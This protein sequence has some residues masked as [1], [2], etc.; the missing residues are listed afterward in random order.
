MKFGTLVPIWHGGAERQ[1]LRL[2]DQ[3]VK[4]IFGLLSKYNTSM[5]AISAG[6]PVMTNLERR[7]QH[8]RLQGLCTKIVNDTVKLKGRIC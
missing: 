5:A 1:I 3:Y 2:S 8:K 4:F 6:L 7:M